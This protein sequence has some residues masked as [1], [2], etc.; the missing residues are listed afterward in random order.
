M[1]TKE[2]AKTRYIDLLNKTGESRVGELINLL[3]KVHF[4]DVPA[5]IDDHDNFPGGLCLY[6][7]KVFE[8]FNDKAIEYSLNI[9]PN[10]IIIVSLLHG[11]GKAKLHKIQDNMPITEKQMWT[12]NNDIKG[13]N[14][15]ITQ[16]ELLKYTL[17]DAS[18]L[19]KWLK[20]GMIGVKPETGNV[21]W[22]F[23]KTQDTKP[24]WLN[25]VK[26]YYKYIDKFSPMVELLLIYQD[27]IY[28]TGRLTDFKQRMQ[29][30]N[31]KEV[32]PEWFFFASAKE[33]ASK[34]KQY[35]KLDGIISDLW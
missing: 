31:A 28:D 21:G 16:E 24:E 2:E 30:Q 8:I 26:N 22:T 13:K 17:A 27:G 25:A 9:S 29:F 33:E 12:I 10:N 6:S 23:D 19:I 20:G 3:E 11:F 18:A 35:R 14:I 15:N 1:I 32:C 4:F 34:A 7:L 5:T